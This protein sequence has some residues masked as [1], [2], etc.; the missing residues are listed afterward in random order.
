MPRERALHGATPQS[1]EAL[2]RQCSSTASQIHV[3]PSELEE[4]LES[5]AQYW[6]PV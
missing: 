2:G 3:D 6:P 4:L 1:K 5:T